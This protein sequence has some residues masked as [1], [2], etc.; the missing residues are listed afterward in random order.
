MSHIEEDDDD[1]SGL[2]EP[3]E[4]QFE[5][6]RDLSKKRFN[7]HTFYKVASHFYKYLT[8]GEADKLLRFVIEKQDEVAS[9]RFVGGLETLMYVLTNVLNSLMPVYPVGCSTGS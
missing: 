9:I 7:P 6:L 2:T 3:N 4:I 5:E 8:H 1:D